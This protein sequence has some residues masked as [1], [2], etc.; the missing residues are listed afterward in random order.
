MMRLLEY[1]GNEFSLTKDL[2]DN[3]PAYAILSHTWGDDG[4]EFT[5]EDLAKG[6]GKSKPGYRKIRFCGEQAARDGLRYF[7]VDTCCIDKSDAAELQ[8][9]INSM[10]QWYKNAARCYVYLPDVSVSEE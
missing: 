5:F 4:Q 9:A 2:L 10:F 7:W 3:I 6:A 1:H 8:S